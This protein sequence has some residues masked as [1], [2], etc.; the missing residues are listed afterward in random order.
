MPILPQ[1]LSSNPIKNASNIVTIDYS[2]DFKDLYS[3]I[4]KFANFYKTGKM[5][6]DMIRYILV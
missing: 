1:P 2:A 5:S 4:N 6:Y 3:R